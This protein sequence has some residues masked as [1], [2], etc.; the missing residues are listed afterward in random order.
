MKNTLLFYLTFIIIGLFTVV[1]S[2]YY[3]TDFTNR[4]GNSISSSD[5]ST[6]IRI[7]NPLLIIQNMSLNEMIVG[8]DDYSTFSVDNAGLALFV[9][10][11][12]MSFVILGFLWKFLIEKFLFFFFLISI[13]FNG[14]I[15]SFDKVLLLSVVFGLGD[16][17]RSERL[18]KRTIIY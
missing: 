15:L 8:V 1:A 16:F 3:S 13:F 6:I 18:K 11:G 17:Y 9:H 2:Y 4:I 14:A 10:Y 12:V 5:K 7:N